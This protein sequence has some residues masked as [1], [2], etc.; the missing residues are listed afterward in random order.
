MRVHSQSL[1]DPAQPRV[2]FLGSWQ[3]FVGRRQIPGRPPGPGRPPRI[4]LTTLLP[5]L[6]FHVMQDV[7]TLAEHFFELTGE[8]LADSSWANRRQRLPWDVFDALLRR[9]LRPLATAAQDDAF[10]RG[11]RLVA[12]DGTQFSLTNTPQVLGR[13]R[14]AKS[15][16][17]AAAFAK[18]QAAVLLEV[19]LHNPLA[20]AIA[21]EG[22][23]EWALAHRLLDALPA[24]AVL[25]M[26][27]LYG[28]GAFLAPTL[29]ACH[30]VGSHVVVRARASVKVGVVNRLADGS[31][32]VVLSGPGTGDARWLHLREVRAQVGRP[33][34]RP[35]A[36]RLWTTL[37]DPTTAP[38]D[39]IVAVYARRWE[40]ELYFRTVKRQLRKTDLLQS[41]T[42]ETAAQEVA[43]IVLASAVLAAERL[44]VGTEATPAPRLSAAKVL[45]V[46]T[47][48]WLAVQL[49]EGVL[50][51]DQITQI[52]DRGYALMRRYL[53]PPPRPRSCP[54][55]VRQPVSGWPRL[56]TRTA[57]AGPVEV[58]LV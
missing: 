54:R 29:A 2:G 12:L 40:H 21:R 31:R 3:R 10:W 44:R 55:A 46:T 57:T 47:A 33:G 18:L 4:P 39:E 17:G 16:R 9:L 53:K 49:G 56:L 7:G 37:L 43:A 22:E 25:L 15:R 8:S 50:A 52:L 35:T 19:G 28:C 20:A 30:R 13:A 36:V 32:L 42:V 45:R 34:H 14:K 23:S 5:A 48:L 24:H 6:I 41:H 27:R 11:W 1:S 51:A 38:A 58:K 26:D